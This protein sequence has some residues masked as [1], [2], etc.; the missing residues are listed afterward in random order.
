VRADVSNPS[1]IVKPSS[2]VAMGVP[3][4]HRPTIALIVLP[5]ILGIVV[6][7]VHD[8]VYDRFNGQVVRSQAQQQWLG[9]IGTGL[10]FLVKTLFSATIGAACVQRLWWILR[11]YQISVKTVDLSI[12]IIS[13]PLHLFHA[14]FFREAPLIVLLA[15]IA[16]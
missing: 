4:T 15:V 2:K 5:F 10:A 7:F 8:T 16:W 13:N 12:G 9:R 1:R 3:K 6:V 11:K 14:R